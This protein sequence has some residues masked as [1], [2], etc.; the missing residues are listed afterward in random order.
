MSY[1]SNAKAV[2]QISEHEL[3][4]AS[5]KHKYLRI[6]VEL[7]PIADEEHHL[8]KLGQ[9]KPCITAQKIQKECRDMTFLQHYTTKGSDLSFYQQHNQLQKLLETP[10]D[11]PAFKGF[12]L[13][14]MRALH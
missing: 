2:I 8:Y 6:G 13:H 4:Y 1:R 12:V 14:Q 3:L 7:M 10:I 11:Y 5:L 9:P